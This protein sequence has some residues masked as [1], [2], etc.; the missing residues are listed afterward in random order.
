MWEF[1]MK[2]VICLTLALLLL[3]LSLTSC[4][5]DSVNDENVVPEGG[6]R[7]ITEENDVAEGSMPRRQYF[8]KSMREEFIFDKDDIL[9]KYIKIYT[10]I[11]DITAEEKAAGLENL[12]TADYNAMIEGDMIMVY[13]NDFLGSACSDHTLE[14]VKT[15]LDEKSVIY[16]VN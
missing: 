14:S 3:T 12:V 4:G 2:K 10:F 5:G 1:L 6:R 15:R 13:N 8:A 9:T 7:L 11:D 16:T